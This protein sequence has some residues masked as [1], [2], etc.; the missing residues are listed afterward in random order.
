MSKDYYKILGVSRDASRDEIKKAYKKLAKKYHPDLNKD[1]EAA[2]K[3]KEINEAAAV[4]GDEQ[5]R[6]QYDQYGTVDEQF[7]QNFNGFDFSSF[8]GGFDFES[9]F[10]SFFGGGGMFGGGFRG[11][12]DGSGSDLRFDLE[13]SLEEAASG[14]TKKIKISKLETCPNCKG[15]GAESP[16]D[17][18]TCTQ[19]R[20]S[21][22]IRRTRRT[23]FGM[24]ATTSACDRCEGTGEEIIKK[25]PVCNG[26]GR[27]NTKK[28]IEINIPAGVRTGTRLRVENEG[29]AG[30][31]GAE[32]G[33]LYIVVYV[34]PHSIF[35]RKEDDIYVN[36]KISF[37]QAALG[38]EIDVPVLG[39]KAKLKIPPGTQPG[40]IF[41]M[42]GKGITHLNGYGK[43]D[44]YVT[45]DV[46]VPEKLTKKQK[47]LLKEFEETFKKKKGFFSR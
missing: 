42:K 15:I 30:R 40:T 33:D 32:K 25:C 36:T 6:K 38:T 29:E 47:E 19:C 1:P 28:S 23:P 14:T 26:E 11:R 35:E 22:F 46:E 37:A 4:L 21:G 44:Q 43:G 31:R 9:I 45:V 2:E 17:I 12:S 41:R 7:G 16:S 24:F 3:F 34:K 39:G 13:I 5:K 27:I 20:G 10:D 18:H 8:R